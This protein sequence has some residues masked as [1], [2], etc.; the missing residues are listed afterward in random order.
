MDESKLRHDVRREIVL[1]S[2]DTSWV[3][4]AVIREYTAGQ[5]SD[6]SGSIDAFKQM[7][8]AKERES[9]ADR[10]HRFTGPVRLLLGTVEHPDQV[11]DDQRELLRASLTDYAA[12]SVPG[13]GQ[14]IPEEQ[15]EAVVAAVARL[16]QAAGE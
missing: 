16:R 15:P 1:N 4:D 8:K 14:Y 10:L 5:A 11:T 3:T 7:S 2:G 6:L 13:S 9:L 12:D